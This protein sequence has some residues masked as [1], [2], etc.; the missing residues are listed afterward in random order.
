VENRWPLPS[1]HAPSY[2]KVTSFLIESSNIRKAYGSYNNLV[3]QASYIR[4]QVVALWD[5]EYVLR[6]FIPF[7]VIS[8]P[9][10]P[11]APETQ[12]DLLPPKVNLRTMH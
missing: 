10:S 1:F 8:H 2:V 5:F 12:R 6:L 9:F 4:G 7:G 11:E 3:L